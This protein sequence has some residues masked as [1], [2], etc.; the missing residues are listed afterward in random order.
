[1]VPKLSITAVNAS[2]VFTTKRMQL[3]IL[4]IQWLLLLLIWQ[5]TA[6]LLWLWMT[7]N[8]MKFELIIL[9]AVGATSHSQ[10]PTYFSNR[11]SHDG[12]GALVVQ[13]GTH[14]RNLP[15]VPNSV[16]LGE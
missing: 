5:R 6:P 7:P 1:V 12:A 15:D 14:G 3:Q 8:F 2:L 9:F 4:L 16:G 11:N 10:R 13:F